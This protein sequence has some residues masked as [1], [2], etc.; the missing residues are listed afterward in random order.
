VLGGYSFLSNVVVCVPLDA[1]FNPMA[2][3][4]AW[5]WPY[6]QKWWTDV[7]I[8]ITTELIILV[9][10]MPFLWSLSL[11]LYRKIGVILLFALGLM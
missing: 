11:P 4:G 5:C 1:F 3:P 7:A 9:L 2:H 6:P 8:H 10:P